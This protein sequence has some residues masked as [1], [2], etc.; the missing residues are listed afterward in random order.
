[1]ELTI[2][3]FEE[4]VLFANSNV[5]KLVKSIVNESSNAAFVAMYEDSVIL[6]D[7]EE[8]KFY[9]ADYQFDP[10]KLTLKL[11]NYEPIE[12]SQEESSF[13]ESVSNFF[14]DEDASFTE[15]TEAYRE[16]VM[17]QEKF[18]RELIAESLSY[19]DLNEEIDYGELAEANDDI[20]IDNE[21]FFEAYKA[22]LETNPLNEVKYFNWKTPIK[23]SLMENEPIKLINSTGTEKAQN[24][25]KRQS[26]KKMF[27]ESLEVFLEDVEEGKEMLMETFKTYPN[28]FLL[29][30]ADRK[31][32][33][34]KTI[35]ANSNL[36]EYLEDIQKGLTII[37]EDE[38][39]R[40]LSENYISE[41]ED[42]AEEA[43]EEDSEEDGEAEEKKPAKELDTEEMKKI[44]DEL[45]KVADKIED[46]A[47]KKKLGDLADKI[48]D[49][50]NEG[51]RPDLIKEAVYYLTI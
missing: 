1:M 6:L 40:D 21:P 43:G 44:S 31:T 18:V 17:G 15:L 20:S 14:D 48:S 30:N 42:S 16:D 27:N 45:N 33:F 13:Q 32:L 24:L 2:Q 50:V 7:H 10:K 22:R 9:T 3:Q 29:D 23:V 41:M 19:K 36:R 11:E 49:S 5:E 46:E 4:T 37:F 12:L 26:F 39:V 38:D 47:V 28:V 51:T 8:G 34:G 35:I 25:W